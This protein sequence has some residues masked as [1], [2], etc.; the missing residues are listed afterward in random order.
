[1]SQ[2]SLSH[3]NIL[4]T[5]FHASAAELQ[6]GAQW[7]RDALRFC[8]AVAESTGLP[9]T[10]VAG[11]TAA[12]SPN[13][14]WPRNQADAERL[15]RTFAAGTL[16]DAAQV[17]VSTFHGNKQKA[18]AI[19]AGDQPLEVLGGLKVRAFY[20]CILGDAGVCVDG[21][22]YAIWLGSYVPTTKTPKLSPKLYESIAAAYGQAA[23]TINTAT[24]ANYSAAQIQAITWTV[25]Q[26]IRREV[27]TVEVGK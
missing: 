23:V 11:V 6:H 10:S 26:R 24:G 22:A 12:L 15:C 19:L 3:G 18:L 17:K 1:M 25:W 16:A 21:H 20:N 14:R 2:L 27:S 5:F 9:L 7:Y 8:A 13:N 4:A